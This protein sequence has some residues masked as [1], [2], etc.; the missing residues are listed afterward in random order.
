MSKITDVQKK[1]NEY[2]KKEHVEKEHMKLKTNVPKSTRKVKSSWKKRYFSAESLPIWKR[3]AFDKLDSD[4]LQYRNKKAEGK[5]KELEA[6]EVQSEVSVEDKQLWENDMTDAQMKLVDLKDER[7]GDR[8]ARWL[9]LHKIL[10]QL[11]AI[12][13]TLM[14]KE[15]DVTSLRKNLDI[16]F[17]EQ[18]ITIA[19]II[20]AV[21]ML[22]WTIVSA[23]TGESGVAGAATGA[24][25]GVSKGFVQKQL[26]RLVKFSNILQAKKAIPFLKFLEPWSAFSWSQ[27]RRL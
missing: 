11:Q 1:L 17:K 27:L 16:F 21:G 13:E 25:G 14:K 3:M 5:I 20:T 2:A 8:E 18:G 24:A 10:G 23:V 26:K 6:I 15:G 9:V 4:I 7:K 22:I 12:K 19:S